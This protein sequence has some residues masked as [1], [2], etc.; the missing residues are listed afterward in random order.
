MR[1]RKALRSRMK[2]VGA[3]DAFCAGVIDFLLDRPD[4][5]DIQGLSVEDVKAMLLQGSA[6]GAACVTFTGATTA[7][8][9]EKVDLL[10]KEP[11]DRVRAG[12]RSG[13]RLI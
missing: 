2:R 1:A 6:A 12:I 8:T 10:M 3:G 11:G 9:R 7:V 5:N 4:L 13:R